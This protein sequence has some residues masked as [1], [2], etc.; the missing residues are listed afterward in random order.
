MIGLFKKTMKNPIVKSSVVPTLLLGAHGLCDTFLSILR[1][2]GL[3][4][5]EDCLR[6]RE[7]GH[8]VVSGV[9]YGVASSLSRVGLL[10]YATPK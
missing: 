10:L 5:A 3:K 7:R 4:P 1:K 6:E 9:Y 2:S 8:H